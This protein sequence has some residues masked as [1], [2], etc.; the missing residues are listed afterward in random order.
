MSQINRK[1]GIDVLK[2]ISMLGIVGLH[3]IN[4]GGFLSNESLS[5]PERN[6]VL[7]LNIVFLSSVNIFAMASGYLYQGREVIKY[8]SAI[9]LIVVT[10]FYCFGETIVF[11]IFKR[12]AFE[13]GRIFIKS[14]FPYMFGEYWYLTSYLFVFI[15]MPYINVLMNHL[16]KKRTK[17]GIMLLIACLSVVA[18]LVPTDFFK[19]SLG[20]SPLW[21]ILCYIIGAYIKE[22]ESEKKIK[23]IYCLLFWILNIICVF[24]IKT[25]IGARGVNCDG[26]I[27]YNSPF[28][29][30]NAIIIF[31][32]LKDINIEG[33]ILKFIMK[34]MSEATFGVY[35][36]HCHFL[37]FSYILIGFFIKQISGTY[38]LV[39]LLA[40]ILVIFLIC[41][42]IDIIRKYIFR[43]TKVN[44]L[45][46][47]I[48]NFIDRCLYDL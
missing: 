23:R 15:I 28:I 29:I 24:V 18:T 47:K 14:L 20:F 12:E 19:V 38:L 43:L 21:L 41:S 44:V 22:T 37:F 36:I 9:S 30:G 46:E 1:Y 39:K 25:Y 35:L 7:I 17:K 48:G 11:Y 8:K 10:I 5:L 27:A 45:C 40:S 34:K 13:S 2:V 16:S 4:Y 33:K 31:M 3:I 32:V 42:M 26:I 6:V